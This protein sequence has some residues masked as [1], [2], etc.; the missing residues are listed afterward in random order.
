MADTEYL[1]RELAALRSALGEVATRD[2]LR[3]EIGRLLDDLE[4][5]ERDRERGR[6]PETASTD[7]D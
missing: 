7:R 4:D 5:R 2:F 1:T 3:S 6:G